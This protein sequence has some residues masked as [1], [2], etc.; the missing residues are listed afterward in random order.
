MKKNAAEFI[1]NFEKSDRLGSLMG[2]KI[3]SLSQEEC[4]GSY[5]ASPA[6]FNPNGILH[7]G[8]L[9]TAMD[10]NQGAF[11]HFILEEKY[12]AAATGTA[13]IK[14]LAPIRGGKIKI[15]TYLKARENR[16]LFINS[17]AS[18]EAGHEVATLEE[19]WIPILP[20]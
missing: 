1:R 9:Y 6:H 4:I 5:E 3:Q 12:I 2:A 7:G 18:D 20:K 8:A 19:I 14:Y 15:R 11:V 16:K 17:S 10:S 13:T